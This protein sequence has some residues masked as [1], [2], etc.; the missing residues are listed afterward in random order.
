MR[1]GFRRAIAGLLLVASSLHARTDGFVVPDAAARARAEA[2]ITQIDTAIR[3]SDSATLTLEKWCAANHMADPP[4]VIVK[5]GRGSAMQANAT[6]RQQLRVSAT[7]PLV[8]R[9][10]LLLCGDHILSEAENWYVPSRLTPE[11]NEALKGSEPFGKVVQPLMPKRQSL[12][13]RRQWAPLKAGDWTLARCSQPAFSHQA[14]VLDGKGQPLALVTEL[15]RLELLCAAEKTGAAAEPAGARAF[16]EAV[17]GRVRKDEALLLPDKLKT[18]A[19]PRLARAI[20]KNSA[21]GEIGVLDYDPFCLCQ[22]NDGVHIELVDVSGTA[23]QAVAT[24]WIW[25]AGAGPSWERLYRMTLVP[26]QGQWRIAD[27]AEKDRKSLLAAL[28]AGSRDTKIRN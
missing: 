28:Q 22:D 24:M 19:T 23:A 8:Y 26:E 18:I 17:L 1:K 25:W 16:I 6:E 15:Y 5:K 12:S 10:V 7:E 2:Q 13:Q 14:L 11:M 20:E 21:G 27:F 9:R 4:Q 3:T